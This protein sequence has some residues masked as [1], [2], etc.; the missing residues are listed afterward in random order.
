M[1]SSTVSCS[2]SSEL[3]M[4]ITWSLYTELAS[5]VAGRTVASPL[6]RTKYSSLCSASSAS[7]LP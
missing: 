4:E 3:T 1:S 5:D 7:A 2:V 6:R